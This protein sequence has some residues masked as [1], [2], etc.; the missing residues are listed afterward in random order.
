MVRR[1][2]TGQSKTKNAKPKKK[3]IPARDHNNRMMQRVAASPN[4]N[5]LN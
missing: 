2:E 5:G 4:K 1:S 3:K